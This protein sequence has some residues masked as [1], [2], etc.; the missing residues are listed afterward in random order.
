VGEQTM[1]KFGFQGMKIWQ[2]AIEV[3]DELFNIADSLEERRL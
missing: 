2:L 3:A 1:V